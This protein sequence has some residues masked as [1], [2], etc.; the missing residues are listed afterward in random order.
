M[1]LRGYDKKEN[2][3]AN[4]LI[5]Q[6]QLLS[7]IK[8]RIA[9]FKKIAGLKDLNKN[10]IDYLSQS[11]MDL[12]VIDIF[13]LFSQS[14]SGNDHLSIKEFSKEFTETE[15]SN[16]IN[17]LTNLY[18][19]NESRFKRMFNLRNKIIAHVDINRFSGFYNL[20]MSPEYASTIA[21]EFNSVYTNINEQ[22]YLQHLE[23][24]NLISSKHEDQRY[25]IID[26]VN[27]LD[28]IEHT[29]HHFITIQEQMYQIFI[30]NLS[31]EYKDSV[32][33]TLI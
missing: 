33:K 32:Q 7:E 16:Q 3:R 21:K 15:Y 18:F 29:V 30:K 4:M 10:D 1:S 5:A 14:D 25:R 9:Y 8:I 13:K 28:F 24:V 31:E 23:S 22:L 17:N 11:L 19:S 12:I 27:D 2:L 26:F 6:G 20:K